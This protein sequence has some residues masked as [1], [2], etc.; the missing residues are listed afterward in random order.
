MGDPYDSGIS[1]VISN[2]YIEE[3]MNIHGGITDIRTKYSGS[4]F[5]GF[6]RNQIDDGVAFLN[7]RGFYGFSNFSSNDVDQLNNG[8]KL[9][10]LIFFLLLSI[11]DVYLIIIGVYL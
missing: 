1:T 6:M 3:I 5:D 7:Y 4:N 11:R 10:F 2:Q 9:P 8:Y